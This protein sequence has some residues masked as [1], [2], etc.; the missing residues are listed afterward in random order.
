[1]SLGTF[2]RFRSLGFLRSFR[3]IFTR[4]GISSIL[5]F[6]LLG[7]FAPAAAESQ[8]NP[9][10]V[11]GAN[12]NT[13]MIYGFQLNPTTGVLTEISGS[14]FNERLAPSA[15][16]VN[17]AGTLLFVA[18][19]ADNDV[20]VFQINTSTGALTEVANSPFSTGIGQNP[21]DLVVD[22]SGKFLYVA[23]GG[24]PEITGLTDDEIDAYVID[25][26]T[27]QL[28]PTPN[29][30]PPNTGAVG[31]A[32][33]VGIFAHPQG[34]WLY[35]AGGT[36]VNSTPVNTINGYLINHTT[37]DLNGSGIPIPQYG[38]L[39]YATSFAADPPVNSPSIP[40]MD[41][42]TASI[43]RLLRSIKSRVH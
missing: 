16:A 7:L 20:S 34:N 10:F 8:T 31:P 11:Y 6:A 24:L 5:T 26:T 27:G 38:Y 13:H 42:Q 35:V 14:P 41:W 39:E 37:G 9:Q 33:P 23:N 40:G 18:N 30:T 25:A 29:S 12:T 15:M 3:E 1:M 21:T 17:P 32:V 43:S 19:G 22:P 28:T 4:I 2:H 36:V